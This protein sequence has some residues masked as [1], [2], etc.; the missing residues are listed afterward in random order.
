[1]YLKLTAGMVTKTIHPARMK[2]IVDMTRIL[3]WLTCFF[4]KRKT[5]GNK[6]YPGLL[7]HVSWNQHKIKQHTSLTYYASVR[8][9]VKI[10][11]TWCNGILI[12]VSEWSVW[13]AR[14]HHQKVLCRPQPITY[15]CNHL[16]VKETCAQ[17]F[18][19]HMNI[20]C[21]RQV[22]FKEG[23]LKCEDSCS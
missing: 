10:T 7:I 21:W 18:R 14:A 23:E 13:H 4:C 20:C 2:R 19:C 1:M 17:Y 22:L 8:K 6:Y 5:T 15:G 9:L 3:V 16:M 11:F 12:Y